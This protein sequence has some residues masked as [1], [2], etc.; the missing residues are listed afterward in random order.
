[1]EAV[2]VMADGKK[3]VP[4]TGRVYRAAYPKRLLHPERVNRL[5]MADVPFCPFCGAEAVKKTAEKG[6]Y[7][8]L[9]CG[10]GFALPE[11]AGRGKNSGDVQA[12]FSST[13]AGTV[14]KIGK[15]GMIAMINIKALDSQNR[16]HRRQA[17]GLLVENFAAWPAME[18]A[19]A[20]ISTLLAKNRICLIALDENDTVVGLAGGLPDYDGNVWELHPLVVKKSEQGRGIG[21]RLVEAIERQARARGAVTMMLGTDDETGATSLSGTDL[22]ENLWERIAHIRNLHDH[23][24]SFYEKCGY[25]IVG[26]VP[27]ANGYGRPDILMAKRLGKKP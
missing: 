2:G 9:R 16:R 13:E 8:C 10:S 22:Y 5:R 7:R 3:R 11:S 1:M 15:D 19:R 18:I 12:G 27:D 25:T 21:R 24:Y 17:A 4:D 14:G 23:P 6:R 26:V 20:E